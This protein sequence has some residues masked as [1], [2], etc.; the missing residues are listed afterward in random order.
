[1]SKGAAESAIV[2]R[3]LLRSKDERLKLQA[4]KI[5]LEQGI[6]RREIAADGNTDRGLAP[7]DRRGRARQAARSD[8]RRVEMSE[9]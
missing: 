4:A 5:V 2:L 9:K 3:K 1:M 8:T 6:N 7:S